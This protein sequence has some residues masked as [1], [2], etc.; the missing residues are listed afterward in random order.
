MCRAPS[1]A[2]LVTLYHKS[3]AFLMCGGGGHACLRGERQLH[4]T[5]PSYIQKPFDWNW[6]NTCDFVAEGQG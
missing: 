4:M 5:L 2:P 1:G 6:Y 3:K